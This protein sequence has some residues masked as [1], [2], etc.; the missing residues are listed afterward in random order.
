MKIHLAI[1]TILTFA[2]LYLVDKGLA[3]NIQLSRRQNP[4][5]SDEVTCHALF[6]CPNIGSQIAQFTPEVSIYETGRAG[7]G[8]AVFGGYELTYGLIHVNYQAPVYGGAS[9]A[10]SV[11]TWRGSQCK[12]VGTSIC[13]LIIY[14][15]VEA[16]IPYP[17][18]TVN[19]AVPT[20]TGQ[21]NCLQVT[22]RENECAAEGRATV[23]QLRM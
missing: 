23:G 18:D 6:N 10:S 14:A 4:T 5:D 1:P 2:A 22:G 15:G 8:Y 17:G 13:N 21:E 11:G 20:I 12:R 3:T 7:S 9:Y 16:E 19:L